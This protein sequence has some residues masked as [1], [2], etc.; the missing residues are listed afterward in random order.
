MKLESAFLTALKAL[1]QNKI[2]SLLTISGVVIGVFAIITLVSLVK[3]VENYVL[4]EFEDLGVSTLF[5]Y[6]GSGG[7]LNDPAL[8]FQNNKLSEKHVQLI[9]KE[10]GEVISQVEPIYQT[11]GVASYRGKQFYATVMGGSSGV[12]SLFSLPI[13]GGRAFNREDGILGE[14]IAII[15]DQVKRELFGE[16]NPVGQKILLEGKSLAVVGYMAPKNP[17]YDPSV[18]LPLQKFEEVFDPKNYTYIAVSLRNTDNVFLHSKMIEMALLKDLTTDDFTIYSSDDLLGVV[19]NILNILKFGLAAIAGISLLVGG[20]GI[21]NIMLVSVTERI[22]EIGL[23]KAVGATEKVIATQFLL[24]A[25]ILSLTGGL[26]G[27]GAG[28]GACLFARQWIQSE[29]TP[30]MVFLA[31]GFSLI[32]GAVFGTYPAVKASKLDAIEAL[33]HE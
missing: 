2:R 31:V 13:A 10:A 4:G 22:R 1:Y 20:I 7:L 3:G 32:V 5:V 33:R 24:E 21:M 11:G 23:R 30:G 9:K 26:V 12:Q 25:S 29:I 16:S 15:G 19:D 8:T 27:L 17:D 14:D 28:F 18:F 6:P